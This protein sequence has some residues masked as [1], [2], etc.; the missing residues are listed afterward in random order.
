[1]LT[2][3]LKLRMVESMSFT[4][5]VTECRYS[6]SA[7]TSLPWFPRVSLTRYVTDAA[8]AGLRGHTVVQ[9]ITLY[10]V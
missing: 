2:S 3:R 10:D 8:A 5:A 9:L 1:M 7:L 4:V 6:C